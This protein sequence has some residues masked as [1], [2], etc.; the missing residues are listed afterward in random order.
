[1]MMMNQHWYYGFDYL[2]NPT[3]TFQVK[4]KNDSLLEVKSKIYADTAT[5]KS[6]LIYKNKKLDRDDPNREQKI[7]AYQ[8]VKI[9]RY[10]G[11]VEDDP[12]YYITGM[13]TDTC[14]LFKVAT[15]KINIYSHLSGASELNNLYLRA[16]QVGDGPIQKIDSAALVSIIKDNPKAMKA[17]K[18]KDYYTA[19]DRFNSSIK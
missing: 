18:K 1:M 9:S 12:G 13:A 10:V 5:H 7:Y 11:Q 15:G 17:F 4:L 2:E 6:Y 14:W 3:Y 16:F 8:T 19:I